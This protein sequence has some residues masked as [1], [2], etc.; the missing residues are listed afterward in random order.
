MVPTEQAQRVLT[1]TSLFR[2]RINRSEPHPHRIPPRRPPSGRPR[3]RFQIPPPPSPPRWPKP[4]SSPAT[5]NS[6]RWKWKS[7]SIGWT[8]YESRTGGLS[9]A[10][11]TVAWICKSPRSIEYFGCDRNTFGDRLWLDE[12]ESDTRIMGIRSAGRDKNPMRCADRIEGQ[13]CHL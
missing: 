1:I 7:K 12:S 5:L 11:V 13:P 9:D 10:H 2:R 4:T 3:R 8:K 6:S